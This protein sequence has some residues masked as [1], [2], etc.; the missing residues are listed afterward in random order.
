MIELFGW[1]A[2]FIVSLALLVKSSDFFTEAAESLG[3]YLGFPRFIVGVTIVSIGTSLPELVSSIFAMLDNSSEI[4]LGNVVGSNIANIFLV[5][6]CAAVISRLS[7]TYDLI[8]VDLPLFV[9]TVFFL[10]LTVWDLNFSKGEA[11]LSLIAYG[12]YLFYA[13]SVAQQEN[14]DQEDRA[15]ESGE[16]SQPDKISPTKDVIILILSS[17]GLCLGAKYTIDSVVEISELLQIGVEIIAVTAVALGTSLPELIV[18]IS[19]A[20]KE[21]PEMAIGNVLGSNIFNTFVVMGI[22][23]LMG[24][25]IIPETILQ[26]AL[27]LMVVA[28]ILF[29]FATQDKQVAKW[30]GLLFFIFYIWFIGQLFHFI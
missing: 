25:I 19:L 17:I 18:T 28:T 6:G 29:V 30:E 1:I 23:G 13:I 16:D 9:G 24:N 10:G 8:N 11:I 22:P 4:I 27:P 5:L 2:L 21:N 7:I 26:Q 15:K 14:Q 20:V 3:I 12:I